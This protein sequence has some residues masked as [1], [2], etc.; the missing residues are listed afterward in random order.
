MCIIYR[1]ILQ[2]CRLSYIYYEYIVYVTND[3]DDE[4]QESQQLSLT[5]DICADCVKEKA[6][7]NMFE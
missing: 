6:A 4:E 2:A 3:D 7:R 1:Y 5:I